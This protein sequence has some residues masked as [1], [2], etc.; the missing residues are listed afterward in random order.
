MTSQKIFAAPK[1]SL[2]FIRSEN[3]PKLRTWINFSPT[4]NDRFAK[5]LFTSLKRRPFFLITN[6][7]HI[8]QPR[9][10]FVNWLSWKK[11]FY[12]SILKKN[13]L[14]ISTRCVS[15]CL[16]SSLINSLI[17]MILGIISWITWFI[18]WKGSLNTWTSSKKVIF[19]W[20]WCQ[21]TM[22]LKN[23]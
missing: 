3:D 20:S 4:F 9:N 2:K 7:S 11:I 5:R 13:Y 14:P 18:A 6:V 12:K 21:W 17:F 1:Y 10:S 22:K 16:S 15:I 8:L 19:S 23:N